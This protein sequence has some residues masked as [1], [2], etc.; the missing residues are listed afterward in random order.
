MKSFPKDT[1]WRS[2][3]YMDYISR[4]PSDLSGQMGYDEVKNE[5]RN[6]PHHYRKG[7]KGGTA[8]KPSD[9]WIISLTHK[10]HVQVEAGKIK[11]DENM[12]MR[13]ALN[14]LNNYLAF[15]GVK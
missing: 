11:L 6:D 9:V 8:L 10:E 3:R 15:H 5:P 4:Q 13:A 12:V 2:K 1:Y 7:S 14:H